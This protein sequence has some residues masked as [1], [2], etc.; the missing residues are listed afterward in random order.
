LIART[1]THFAYNYANQMAADNAGFDLEKEWMS[2]EDERTRPD[3]A[4]ADGQRVDLK[5]AFSIG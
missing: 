1:E 3:H 2:A 4:D 5:E